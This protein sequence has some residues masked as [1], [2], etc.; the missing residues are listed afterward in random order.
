[1]R[2]CKICHKTSRM[3][4]TRILLRGHYNPTNWS[5]KY[6]NLQT[7]RIPADKAGFK[8]GESV[9]VCTQCIR[10]FGKAAR[11]EKKKALKAAAVPV[12]APVV[13]AAPVAKKEEAK[14]AKVK[15]ARVAS[16]NK[17]EVKKTA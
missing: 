9:L 16:K 15:K 3:V 6:P 5:R 8:A 10:T 2:Q 12:A 13:K 7:I 14:P 11:L 17:K 1:M 4:G